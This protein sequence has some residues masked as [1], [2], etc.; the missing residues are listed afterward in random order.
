MTI[1]VRY[2]ER[3]NF[4]N[5]KQKQDFLDERTEVCTPQTCFMREL[6]VYDF[7]NKRTTFHLEI[8]HDHV[9]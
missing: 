5:L 9:G 1:H 7:E 8:K 3:H 4:W 2:S 6:M